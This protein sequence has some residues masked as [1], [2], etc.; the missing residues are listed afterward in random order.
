MS[1][2]IVKSP[3]EP[4]RVKSPEQ[5]IMKSPDPV[6]WTVPL[7]T[8]KTFT[9]TQNVKEGG[10]WKITFPNKTFLYIF[11][12]GEIYPRPQSEIKAT[13]PVEKPPP[14]PQSAP[15]E[16]SEQV[17]MEGKPSQIIKFPDFPTVLR[18]YVEQYLGIRMMDS[19]W[20]TVLGKGSVSVWIKFKANTNYT[21]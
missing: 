12:S 17:K 8:G 6:N 10:F 3:P 14:P 4:T 2:P 5:I 1:E 19:K 15:P 20:W 21:Y 11:F 16:Y 13:T 9:V 18:S 7:D